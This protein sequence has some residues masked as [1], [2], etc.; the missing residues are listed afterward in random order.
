MQKCFALGDVVRLKSGGPKMTVINRVES[1][2]TCMW[3][4]GF[5]YS[6]VPGARGGAQVG[7][8]LQCTFLV[9]A[10]VPAAVEAED[11]E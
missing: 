6:E 7:S 10:L 9:E 5:D 2:I 8:P 4:P 11:A 3:F 1:A